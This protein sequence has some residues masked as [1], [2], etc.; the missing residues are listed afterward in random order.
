MSEQ[1]LLKILVTWVLVGATITL[2]FASRIK[3][4]FPIMAWAIGGISLIMLI[5]WNH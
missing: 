4:V 1:L 5:V 3:S 2:F